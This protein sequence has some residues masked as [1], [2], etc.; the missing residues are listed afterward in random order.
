MC[1]FCHNSPSPV[2][3]EALRLVSPSP[4]NCSICR[5]EHQVAK[6]KRDHLNSERRERR[7]KGRLGEIKGKVRE[8]E[9]TIEAL[10]NETK[11]L[12]E[13]VG[14]LTRRNSELKEKV[15]HFTARYNS[16]VR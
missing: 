2:A 13:Q 14:E 12:H 11:S 3:I 6:E 1:G 10:S 8:L 5:L 7:T 4:D 15:R 16:C 9:V